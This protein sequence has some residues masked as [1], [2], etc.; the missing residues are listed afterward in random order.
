MGV[1]FRQAR[2]TIHI[3]IEIIDHY[4]LE[5]SQQMAVK[6]FK[7]KLLHPGAVILH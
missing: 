2:E 1:K 3:A 7:T 6:T 4:Y 5:M